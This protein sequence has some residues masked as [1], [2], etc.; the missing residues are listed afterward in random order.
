VLGGNVYFDDNRHQLTIGSGPE[1]SLAVGGFLFVLT[2]RQRR[3]PQ[4]ARA[5][6]LR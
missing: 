1:V 3:L 2:A 5:T 4:R 6:A